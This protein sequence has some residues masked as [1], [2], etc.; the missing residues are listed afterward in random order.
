[1]KTYTDFLLETTDKQADKLA[2]KYGYKPSGE[3]TKHSYVYMNK[4][5]NRINFAKTTS[6]SGRAYRNFEAELRRGG[7]TVGGSRGA[8]RATQG[9]RFQTTN[10]KPVTRSTTQI[11]STAPS[12]RTTI[13][14]MSAGTQG[15]RG[16]KSATTGSTNRVNSPTP[17]PRPTLNLG[18]RNNQ[19]RS[20][21]SKLRTPSRSKPGGVGMFG[22]TD[23][24]PGRY[25]MKNPYDPANFGG[26]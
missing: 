6:D 22:Q 11:R 10:T 13:H 14:P 17:R 9:R 21:Q 8:K 5:G 12:S 4:D 3:T 7:S 23:T 18:G 20:T 26:V 15:G 24:V 19:L 1:M 25:G 2:A 16:A